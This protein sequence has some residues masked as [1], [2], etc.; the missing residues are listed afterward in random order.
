MRAIQAYPIVEIKFGVNLS[1]SKRNNRLLLPTPAEV[2]VG[3]QFCDYYMSK[4]DGQEKNSAQI[5]CTHGLN[6]LIKHDGSHF[7]CKTAIKSVARSAH[8]VSPNGD[9][10]IPLSPMTNNLLIE[11]IVEL[12]FVKCQHTKLMA[13]HFI[14]QSQYWALC[15]TLAPA[16]TCSCGYR[17]RPG[18]L[19]Q[20]VSILRFLSISNSQPAHFTNILYSHS[21]IAPLQRALHTVVVHAF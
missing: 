8:T 7:Y 6:R 10:H 21:F 18:L 11:T 20:Y 5:L 16:M 17:V 14:R 1:S 4:L 19:C 2:E 3:R 15:V 12:V 13:T 9:W